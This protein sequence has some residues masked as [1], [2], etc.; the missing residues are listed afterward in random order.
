M[1]DEPAE[2]IEVQYNDVADGEDSGDAEDG[3]EEVSVTLIPIGVIYPN[4][5]L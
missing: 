3:D 2:V 4:M 1:S 5:T